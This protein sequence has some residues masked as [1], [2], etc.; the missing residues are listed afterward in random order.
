MEV[1]SLLRPNC[2]NFW[3]LLAQAIALIS[4]TMTAALIVPLMFGTTHNLSWLAYAFGTVMLLLVSLNINQFAKRSTQAGSMYAYTS[5][6]LGPTMGGISGWCLIWAYQSIGVAGL[7]GFTVF[8]TKLLGMCG[9]NTDT[10]PVV[11]AV[12]L[13]ASCVALVWFFAWKDIQFSTILMLVLEG[14]SMLFIVVLCAIVLG[15]HH[16]ALDTTQFT[17]KD[18]S[19]KDMGLGVVVA[20]FSLVGFECATAF[21]EEA[22]NPL[23]TIPRAV[24]A[25]LIVTGLFFVLVTYVEVQDLRDNNPPLDQ[26][27][28]P[29]NTM[30]ELAHVKWMAPIVSIGAMLSFFSLALSCMNAGSRIMFAMGRHGIF[31]RSTAKS[32]AINETPHVAITIVSAL[33][34]VIPTLVLFSG[35]V[36]ADKFSVAVLDIFN[37]A[38]VMGAFG[39]TAAY[40]L[41]SFAAPA[42]LKH[43]K[44]LRTLDV[45]LCVG[46][47]VCLLVPAVGSVYPVPPFPVNYFPYIFL[48]YLAIGVIWV[49][50]FRFRVPERLEQIRME[51]KASHAIAGSDELL[52]AEGSA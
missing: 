34:L 49:L 51:L 2:L 52:A 38:G 42:Y 7:T 26:L 22:K 1:K 11:L 29:L 17:F 45:V 40:F 43:E 16:F 21:G 8:S 15:K 46:A 23:K 44:Q 20:I 27:D 10:H 31:H 47:V 28:A 32:H 36:N 33:L 12:V 18:A 5:R 35:H 37:W 25:S 13:F 39:F 9:M 6:G 30:A 24:I 41:I 4:P 19:L 3:E 50:S 14:I 48:A